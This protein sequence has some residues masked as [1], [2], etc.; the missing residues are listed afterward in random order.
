[1][2]RVSNV[3]S[4]DDLS[5][6]TALQPDKLMSNSAAGT[7]SNLTTTAIHNICDLLSVANCRKNSLSVSV[8]KKVN[9]WNDWSWKK[10]APQ[11]NMSIAAGGEG[12]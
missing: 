10:S 2:F 7:D 8:P 11:H 5:L 1:M 12:G 6:G 4:E 9:S 3:T